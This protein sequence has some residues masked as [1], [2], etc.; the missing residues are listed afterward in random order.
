MANLVPLKADVMVPMALSVVVVKEM[1]SS[2][3]SSTDGFV[4]NGILK[5]M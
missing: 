3:S 5:L 4:G 1:G 2:S